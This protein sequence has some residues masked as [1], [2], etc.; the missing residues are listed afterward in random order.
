MPPTHESGGTPHPAISRS[1][2]LYMGTTPSTKVKTA[3]ES[4]QSKSLLPPGQSIKLDSLTIAETLEKLAT[5]QDSVKRLTHSEIAV[6]L[7]AAAM[8]LREVEK[9]EQSR[10]E[11]NMGEITNAVNLNLQ[12]HL[13]EMKSLSDMLKNDIIKIIKTQLDSLV[14]KKDNLAQQASN[15]LTKINEKITIAQTPLTNPTGW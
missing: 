13:D 3:R 15:T 6:V 14:A 8:I 7:I 2:T 5:M 10:E 12:S 11:K 4:L 9:G 1:I